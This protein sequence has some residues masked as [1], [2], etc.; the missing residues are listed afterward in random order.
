MLVSKGNMILFR[1][2]A[3]QDGCQICFVLRC[4]KLLLI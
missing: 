1:A 3:M 2:K 4:V